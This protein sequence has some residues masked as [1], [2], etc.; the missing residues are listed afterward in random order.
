MTCT[1]MNWDVPP[2]AGTPSDLCEA[3][4][5]MRADMYPAH[6]RNPRTDPMWKDR[7]DSKVYEALMNFTF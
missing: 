3:C 1:H 7:V 6:Q 2:S 5:E 4:A